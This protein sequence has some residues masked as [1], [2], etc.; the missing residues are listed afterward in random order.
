MTSEEFRPTSSAEKG[1]ACAHSVIQNIVIT[2]T[3]LTARLLKTEST[4]DRY[5]RHSLYSI[6]DR[7]MRH[8]LYSI[9]DRYLRHTLY[10]ISDR[11]RRHSL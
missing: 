8:S 1:T 6:C 5:K 4:C 11:Y 3:T 2:S 9:C 7:Y 10:N